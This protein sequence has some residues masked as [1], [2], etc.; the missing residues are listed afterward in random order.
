M[1]RKILKG[2]AIGI[3][4]GAPFIATLTQFPL[5]IDRSSEATV[6]GL[7]VLFAILSAIPLFKSLKR[8]FKTPTAPVLWGAMLCLLYA[9]RAILDEMILISF[10][11]L[12]SNCVGWVM[13]KVA[14]NEK[15]ELAKE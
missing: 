9:L 2:C 11:G 3:S 8:L 10:V 5:W 15:T 1:K 12:V 4:V 14:G 6:S 13:F 7:V